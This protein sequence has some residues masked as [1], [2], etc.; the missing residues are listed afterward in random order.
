MNI[1]SI[2]TIIGTVLGSSAVTMLIQYFIGKRK[3]KVDADTVTID[4][5]LKW[6]T[7]LMSQITELEKKIDS[8]DH[9][10]QE[11]YKRLEGDDNGV[12]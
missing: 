8:R 7:S 4:N 2:I 3:S 10:I 5:I 6:A 1:D 12:K 9:A 11:L